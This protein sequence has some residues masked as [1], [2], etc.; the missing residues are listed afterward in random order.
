MGNLSVPSISLEVLDCVW[1]SLGRCTA[2]TAAPHSGVT[3]AHL[4]RDLTELDRVLCYGRLTTQVTTVWPHLINSQK[5]DV[6]AIKTN[7]FTWFVEK[8][9]K[10][11]VIHTTT[12]VQFCIIFQ[13]YKLVESIEAYLPR[14]WLILVRFWLI[15]T[16]ICIRNLLKLL[17]F[18]LI[19]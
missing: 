17:S 10:F 19:N 16:R 6:E 4:P 1:E 3:R 18:T 2:P 7:I 15:V 9:E 12:L 5:G 8:N 11:Y 14:S 13:C